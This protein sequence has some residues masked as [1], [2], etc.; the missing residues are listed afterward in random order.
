MR[1][2]RLGSTDLTVSEIGFG[3]WT[4][5]TNWWGVTDET[6]RLRLLQRAVDAGITFFDTADT[7]GNGLGETILAKALKPYDDRLV[8]AT[9]FGYDFY[10]HQSE[11]RGQEELPQDWSPTYI[12]FAVEESLQRLERDTID[13]YQLHNPR[14][15]AMQR[16]DTFAE[17]EHLRTAGKIRAYGVALGP[18]IAERQIT[19]GVDA[20]TR[21]HVHSVYIIY[22]LFE[23][24]LGR[25]IFPTARDHQAA[26]LVRVPHAS[27]LLEGKFTAGT[28]FSGNDHRYHRISTDERK[29]Q[30]LTDGLKKVDAVQFLANGTGRTLAQAA[31]QFVLSEPS[32]ASVVPNIYDDDQLV[33]FAGASDGVPLT[34]EELA[35][36][37]TLAAHDFLP[38][39][40]VAS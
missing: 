26:M 2:R 5:S 27:G 11:R 30:W 12:R 23:Q 32:V 31:L 21:R 18:A 25:G 15:E 29:K 1:Y 16:D 37:A 40:S 3:V 28:T 34:S 35:Q 24:M 19:E 39:A 8:I 10:H 6:T 22:N 4:V 13:L 33:A 36:L 17:L 20:I 38:Q 9:K 7:Y 14:L